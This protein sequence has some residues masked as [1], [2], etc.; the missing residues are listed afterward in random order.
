M[1]L[2]GGSYESCCRQ[3]KIEEGEGSET[4]TDESKPLIRSSGGRASKV[5]HHRDKSYES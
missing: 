4:V 1:L 2:H 3:P 5:M